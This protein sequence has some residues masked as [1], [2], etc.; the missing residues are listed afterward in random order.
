MERFLPFPNHPTQAL[1]FSLSSVN[2]WV[3]SQKKNAPLVLCVRKASREMSTLSA[4]FRESLLVNVI[5]EQKCSQIE[6]DE[7][8]VDMAAAFY[9]DQRHLGAKAGVS[10]PAHFKAKHSQPSS[11]TR[12][13]VAFSS[14]AWGNQVKS[15]FHIYQ[16]CAAT[17]NVCKINCYQTR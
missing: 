11:C 7:P 10:F 4:T 6:N 2:I 3:N 8:P 15:R 17:G 16:A 1:S 9:R 5:C 13:L 12:S 14:I